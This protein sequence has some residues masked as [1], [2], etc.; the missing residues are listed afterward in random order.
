MKLHVFE[1]WEETHTK[2]D[3][4]IVLDGIL[5]FHLSLLLDLGILMAIWYF[6]KVLHF[7]FFLH[8]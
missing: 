3:Y 7:P 5:K 2:F 6:I 8:V 1:L 4:F